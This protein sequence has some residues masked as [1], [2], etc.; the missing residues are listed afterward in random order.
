MAGP[1]PEDKL[2]VRFSSIDARLTDKLLPE[3]LRA[4]YNVK[5]FIGHQGG[6]DVQLAAKLFRSRED[7]SEMAESLMASQI[8]SGCPSVTLSDVNVQRATSTPP[9]AIS[10]VFIS[11]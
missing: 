4:R 8:L 9:F 11:E 5:L 1:S 7:V 10:V 2:G 3:A 6:L